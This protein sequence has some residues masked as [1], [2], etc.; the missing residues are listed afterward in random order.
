MEHENVPNVPKKDFIVLKYNKCGIE[1]VK[2][3]HLCF[4]VIYNI[5]KK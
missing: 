4:L 1:L 5:L 2:L 3:E